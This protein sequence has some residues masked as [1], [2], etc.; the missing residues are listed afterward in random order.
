MTVTSSSPIDHEAS[1]IS[2][3]TVNDVPPVS[4]TLGD[5]RLQRLRKHTG[6]QTKQSPVHSGL[7]RGTTKGQKAA[8][9]PPDQHSEQAAGKP[10]KEFGLYGN[11]HN[12][13]RISFKGMTDTPVH[14]KD[15]LI[16]HI[17][18]ALE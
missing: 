6:G 8:A 18:A 1:T 2:V 14:F 17:S 5:W 3:L 4:Q 12:R 9:P 15:A 11:A 7:S 10:L 16:C 13:C